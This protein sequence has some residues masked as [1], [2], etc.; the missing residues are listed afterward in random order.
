MQNLHNRTP[1]G[2]REIHGLATFEYDQ[3][4]IIDV[5]VLTLI[6][7]EPSW[8][9]RTKIT[10]NFLLAMINPGTYVNKYVQTCVCSKY[11]V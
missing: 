7:N 1:L 3:R 2:F 11:G 5:R 6:F 9:M 8:K 4:R 10:K